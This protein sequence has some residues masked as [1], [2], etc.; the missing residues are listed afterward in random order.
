[1][2]NLLKRHCRVLLELGSVQY[3]E[4]IDWCDPDPSRGTTSELRSWF[5]DLEGPLER[6]SR[7]S[8]CVMG[9]ITPA[10][11]GGAINIRYNVRPILHTSAHV[12]VPCRNPWLR[13][14]HAML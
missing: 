5:A 1:M 3:N 12:S 14:N 10:G 7:A 11:A 13:E 6:R 8:C 9:G 4:C 2:L